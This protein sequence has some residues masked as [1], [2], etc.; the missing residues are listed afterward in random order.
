MTKMTV[1][2]LHDQTERAVAMAEAG[3][4]VE[5]TR[6]GR[7]VA[8]LVPRAPAEHMPERREAAIADLMAALRKGF[9]LGGR[10]LTIEDRYGHVEA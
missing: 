7:V 8:E 3:V 10:K 9:P 2:D 1:G 6:D 5:V 4:K